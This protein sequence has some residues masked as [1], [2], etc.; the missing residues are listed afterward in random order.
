MYSILSDL[1]LTTVNSVNSAPA[2]QK[3]FYLTCPQCNSFCMMD[4]SYFY[5]ASITLT[6]DCGYNKKLFLSDYLLQMRNNHKPLHNLCKK[7][8]YQS[9]ISFCLNCKS[10]LCKTCIESGVHQSHSIKSLTLNKKYLLKTDLSTIAN[11][12]ENF[13][14]NLD[15]ILI[16]IGNTRTM[17]NA[18]KKF[19]ANL[20]DIQSYLTQL[21]YCY[22][23]IHS[24]YLQQ[25]VQSTDQ[26]DES[27]L[28]IKRVMNFLLTY[29][30]NN[31]K[32]DSL[33]LTV[34]ELNKDNLLGELYNNGKLQY[35]GYFNTNT[36][37]GY[38]I[39]DSYTTPL[40]FG[41]SYFDN[42]VS[43]RDIKEMAMEDCS[44]RI[45]Y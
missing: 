11:T 34:L 41:I 19:Y 23:T 21:Y 13:R 33:S 24:F 29:L 14:V 32:K 16:K 2:P 27:I 45:K 31:G 36:P 22:E 43:G 17:K 4:T 37:N 44:I 38:G 10:H 1:T 39:S 20:L 15:N 25:T 9:Y 12:V 3:N 42:S 6:C 8:R 40:G 30:K 18:I 5:H 28:G 35:R 7:H 26:S